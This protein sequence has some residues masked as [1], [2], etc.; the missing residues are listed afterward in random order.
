[1]LNTQKKL[2]RTISLKTVKS[3][4]D[5]LNEKPP[6]VDKSLG[7]DPYI[8]F[9]EIEDDDKTEEEKDA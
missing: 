6:P 9:N 8:L 7:L 2:S 4:T 3:S 1:M 5:K